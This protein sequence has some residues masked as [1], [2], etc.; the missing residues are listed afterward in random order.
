MSVVCVDTNVLVWG[1]KREASPGRE[2]MI[3][4]TE[5]FLQHMANTHSTV[6]V[7]SIV[8]AELLIKVPGEEHARF[9]RL[10]MQ[11]F[12]IHSFDARVAARF[13]ALWREKRNH[14]DVITAQQAGVT[15]RTLLRADCM[16]V[17]TAIVAG[18]KCIVTN[19]IKDLR[20]FADH[21][22]SVEDIPETVAQLELL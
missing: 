20:R 11:G 22:I 9:T 3:P 16:V 21:H 2:H 10:L 4:R 18:A 6:V 1:V 13:A 7:P 15:S 17:A 14:P 19:N 8:L 12:E 5:A